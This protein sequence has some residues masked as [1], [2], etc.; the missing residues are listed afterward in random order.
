MS[1]GIAVFIEGRKAVRPRDLLAVQPFSGIY[2]D[3]MEEP[4]AMVKK[5]SYITH[6]Q[7]MNIC[8]TLLQHPNKEKLLS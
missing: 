5:R 3:P 6:N 1:Y 7:I 8:R 2:E 4:E